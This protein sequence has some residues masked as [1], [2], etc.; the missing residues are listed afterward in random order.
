MKSF[1]RYP[2]HRQFSAWQVELTTR[3]PLRCTMCVR[4]EYEDWKGKDMDIADFRKIVPHLNRVESVV[5]EG[6]G[7][8]LLH[9]DLAEC[10]GL[11][12]K[13]GT[14]VGF[15]TSGMGLDE[16]YMDRLINAGLDF[17]GFSLAG[18][19]PGTHQA[20]RVNS[21]FGRLIDSIRLFQR[22]GSR[23]KPHRPKIH[24]V[25]LMLKDNIHEVPLLIDLASEIGIP[26]VVLINIIQV[27]NI[28]QAEQQVFS[29]NNDEPYKEI[30]KEANRKAKRLKINLVTPTLTPRE[31][32]VCSENPLRNLYISVEGEVSPCV[33]LH[34]HAPSPFKRIFQGKEYYVEKVSFGNIFRE[35]LDSIWN[36]KEY[37]EF[38]DRFTQR[39]LRTEEAYRALLELKRP[40]CV[41]LPEP[42]DPGKTCHKMLGF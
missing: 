37:A 6:W 40:G 2:K 14:Q 26:E 39:K 11:I 33:H 21:D 42:P 25:Y 15:V 18:A 31:M 8:S 27:T 32:A 28:W 35:S 23:Q 4:Q 3:C 29:Y 17:I 30:L 34:P 19:T 16:A 9:K 1:F 22:L 5:L 24:I 7:E 41:G 20:I 12:K 10:I 36:K 38:R 13:E